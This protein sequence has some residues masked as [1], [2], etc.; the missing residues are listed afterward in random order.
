[1]REAAPAVPE[2]AIPDPP[3]SPEV[4]V[5][6]GPPAAS[7]A[8]GRCRTSWDSRPVVPRVSG[9]QIPILVHFSNPI[10]DPPRP[11]MKKGRGLGE[12][13]AERSRRPG[14]EQGPEGKLAPG[15]VIGADFAHPRDAGRRRAFRCCASSARLAGRGFAVARREGVWG[16]VGRPPAA[17]GAGLKG[18]HRENWPVLPSVPDH[19]VRQLC[20]V[21]AVAP[22]EGVQGYVSRPPAAGGA[23]LK[24]P[25]REN[26]RAFPG[27]T[28]AGR[29][30]RRS[31][32]GGA[33]HR[34]SPPGG[35]CH[36]ERRV[37]LPVG[38]RSIVAG[39]GDRQVIVSLRR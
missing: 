3:A 25:H 14:L 1:M 7:A 31:L 22:G 24:G 5:T 9:L 15:R 8:V 6:L 39:S 38:S 11:A 28:T 32:P 26:W 27:C 23:G 16:Y 36:G 37:P 29:A 34:K 4:R 17:G 20:A 12:G 10:D 33:V 2:Q 18:P 21:L 19:R 30:G 35:G 13:S